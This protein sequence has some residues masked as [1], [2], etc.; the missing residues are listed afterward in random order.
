MPDDVRR[1]F[2]SRDQRLA[3]LEVVPSD[4]VDGAALPALARDLRTLD[5]SAVSTVAGTRL[6]VGGVPALNADYADAIAR[7]TPLSCC[8]S[9]SGR[10]SPLRSGS[11]RCSC[12]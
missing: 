11:N 5:A 3:L 6:L 8:S 10:C 12:R 9:W 2:V 7:R 1:S 4:G